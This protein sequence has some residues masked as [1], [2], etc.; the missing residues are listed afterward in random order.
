[1]V[2][3]RAVIQLLKRHKHSFSD[4]VCL[5]VL[6]SRLGDHLSKSL[7]HCLRQEIFRQ[8][9]QALRKE[10]VWSALRDFLSP[11]MFVP[12]LYVTYTPDMNQLEVPGLVR[13]QDRLTV[14]E[15]LHHIGLHHHGHSATSLSLK[16]FDCP[17]ISHQEQTLT[18]HLLSGFP[19]LSHLVLWKSCDDSML[20]IVGSTCS[21]LSSIDIWRS[22]NATDRGVRALL[23]LDLARPNSVCSSFRKISIKDT[24]ISDSGAF[25]ILIHCHSL[26]QLDFSQ[27]SFL[28]QLQWRIEQN[29]LLTETVFQLTTV[30]LQVIK[31]SQLQH[32]V[33]SLP[34]LEDLTIWTAMEEAKSLTA[35]DLSRVRSLKLGGLNHSSFLCNMIHL[36]GGQLTRL[37]VETV[38]FDIDI[39]TIGLTCPVLQEIHIINA[40]VKVGDCTEEDEGMM[41]PNLIT[42]YFFL[43]QYLV[44]DRRP[45]HSSGRSIS[46]PGGVAHPST[47]H[48]ALHTLLGAAKN[49]ESVQ[50]SG[51]PALTD[52]CMERI[53]QFNPLVRLK[54][55]VISHPLSLG[56]MVVPL[57]A[58]SVTRI[59]RCCPLLECLG[60][61][62]HWAVT[63]AQRRRL[64]RSRI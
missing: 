36:I 41:F 64:G 38:H 43:V 10:V 60:D 18:R 6:R 29:F 45:G 7:P 3:C 1:M 52:S 54:R 24:S 22:T 61:L 9:C 33:K 58:L 63:P 25:Q 31:P 4:H 51:S 56:H 2:W 21:N 23:G 19:H 53:L 20:E 11:D 34:L 17:S 59:Q 39:H 27:D 26:N 40:R 5:R 49:L 14:M 8:A 44:S 13:L 62:K 12:F 46:A 42:I 35:E 50:V 55:L 15:F 32:V 47:G 48:T 16:M 57:T 30:F 37:K 28:Q